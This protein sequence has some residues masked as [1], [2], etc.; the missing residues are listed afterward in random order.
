MFRLK[1]TFE[2]FGFFVNER[3]EH[4]YIFHSLLLKARFVFNSSLYRS[5]YTNC[6]LI[7]LADICRIYDREHQL[8]RCENVRL[9]VDRHQSCMSMCWTVSWP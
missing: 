3:K 4:V 9:S 6:L 8:H 5:D 1:L 7:H 2:S